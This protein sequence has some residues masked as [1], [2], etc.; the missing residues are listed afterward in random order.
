MRP[1]MLAFCVLFTSFSH[2]SCLKN[3]DTITLTGML[4][5]KTYQ[6]PE[7]VPE[8]VSKL[9]LELDKPLDCMVDVDKTFK[10]WN[11]DITLSPPHTEK[12]KSIEPLI[13]K[14]V[15]VSGK[16]ALAVTAYNFTA[17]LLLADNITIL[18]N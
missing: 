14:H 8:P 9:V 12:Y 10:S 7:D 2:A 13:D 5:S 3:G 18:N 11:K 1:I 17:I 6:S 15:F 16:L 4:V